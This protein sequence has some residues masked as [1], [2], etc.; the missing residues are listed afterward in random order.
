MNVESIKNAYY[1][2]IPTQVSFFFN[3]RQYIN[4]FLK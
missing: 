1:L 3:D 2:I 4:H